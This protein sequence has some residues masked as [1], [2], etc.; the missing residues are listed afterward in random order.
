MWLRH[1]LAQ[2]AVWNGFSKQQLSIAALH[3][4]RQITFTLIFLFSLLSLSVGTGAAAAAAASSSSIFFS[5]K[6]SA[7]IISPLFT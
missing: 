3:T 4:M 7:L 5:L 6:V 2:M 1:T